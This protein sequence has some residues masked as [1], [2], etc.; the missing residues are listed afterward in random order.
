[1]K[2]ISV[3]LYSL[4]AQAEKDFVGVLKQLAAIGYKGV[5]PAGFWNLSPLEFK[6]IVTDLGMEVSSTHSP[7]VNPNNTQEVIETAGILD[8]DL[9]TCG[10][11]PDDFATIDAIKK[12]ADTVNTILE[13]LQGSGLTLV[14]HNHF[15]EFERIAGQIKY[16]IFRHYC[17]GV[18][19]EL[20]TYWA[21]NFGAE[22]PVE[23]LSKY[24]HICPLLHIKDGSFLRDKA[25]LALGTGKNNIKGIVNAADPDVLR[26]L[27]VE[28]D[29]C[30]T[31]MVEAV[32]AS[33]RYL[34]DNNLGYGNK[35]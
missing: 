30:D 28:L 27:V 12:T 32:A 25:F 24:K 22:N 29:C 3:Q 26:W 2:P 9:V 34:V 14:Q 11:G 21:A 5:E 6:K 4:R 31:D 10:F 20:D 15:W 16:D 13:K 7:W 33:Y 35:K 19:F 18:K 8:I 17:P 23:Q 1:M